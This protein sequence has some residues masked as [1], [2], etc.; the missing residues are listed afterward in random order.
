[1]QT[2]NSTSTRLNTVSFSP[3]QNKKRVIK[4]V[5]RASKDDT[6]SRVYMLLSRHTIYRFL[7][8]PL[9]LL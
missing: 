7:Y 8:W 5:T 2:I 9:V 6:D 1:M 3:K 4:T